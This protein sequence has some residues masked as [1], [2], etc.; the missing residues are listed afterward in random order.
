MG[1]IQDPSN[2]VSIHDE[3]DHTRTLTI[4]SNGRARIN[5]IDS[6]GNEAECTVDG[7]LKTDATFTGGSVTIEDPDD[8]DEKVQTFEPETGKRSLYVY[9]TNPNIATVSSGANIR[10][11]E[12]TNDQSITTGPGYTT[13]YNNTTA[14]KLFSVFIRV[15]DEDMDLIIDIDGNNVIDEI[16]LKDLS[17]NYKLDV[18]AFSQLPR[19]LNVMDGGK[20]ASME[21]PDKA[22][23]ET[24]I[25][26]KLKAASSGKKLE[27]GLVVR[28]AN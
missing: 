3:S 20:A 19:N 8:S 2:D 5:I 9:I 27:R 21:F 15:E 23:Y 10:Y 22:P 1:D 18:A 14:G 24:N 28:A 6:S 17:D 25:T 12:M 11:D 4:D 7:K 16:N 26:V 13:V